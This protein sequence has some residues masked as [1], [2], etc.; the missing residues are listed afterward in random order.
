MSSELSPHPT[1]ETHPDILK[2]CTVS[3]TN[4]NILEAGSKRFF[5]FTP[6]N[7]SIVREIKNHLDPIEVQ[8]SRK[9]VGQVVKENAFELFYYLV[10]GGLEIGGIIWLNYIILPLAMAIVPIALLTF[11][12]IG[13]GISEFRSRLNEEPE[14][15]TLTILLWRQSILF[16]KQT[17]S[18]YTIQIRL[19]LPML[20][21]NTRTCLSL[22]LLMKINYLRTLLISTYSHYSTKQRLCAARQCMYLILSRHK[23][24]LYAKPPKSLNVYS[25]RW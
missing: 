14:P 6:R 16:T 11:A 19:H 8:A 5:I 18:C 17:I 20:M 23:K 10:I 21:T 4:N 1:P 12:F 25:K 15:H 24:S 7:F 22:S 3:A 2:M 13:F 9:T